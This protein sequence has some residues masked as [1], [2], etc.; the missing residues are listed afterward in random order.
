LALRS[1]RRRRLAAGFH[2]RN[3]VLV[4]GSRAVAWMKQYFEGNIPRTEYR[5]IGYFSVPGSGGAEVLTGRDTATGGPYAEWS[6]LG[7]VGDLGQILIST[8]IH[9][10]IVIQP[11]GGSDWLK[12]VVDD[13]DYFGITVR[14]VP[15]PLLYENLRDLR[16]AYRGDPFNLPEIVLKP[17]GLESDALFVKRVFDIV[18]GLLLLLLTAPLLLLIA[19]AIKLTTPSLPVLYRWRVVG[20]KG[21]PF[22]SYKF[23]TMVA[24]ADQRK[25]ALRSRNE[26]NGPVFKMKDDPRA[27]PLGQFLR[28]YSLNELP[29]I[30]SVVRG[31]MSLVGPRPAFPHEL[32]RYELWH[33]RKLSVRPG[34]T[35][36]WQTRGRNRINNFDDWVRMDLEYIDNWSLWLDLKILIRTAWVVVAGTGS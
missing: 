28:R 2:A 26:M 9:E 5:A 24:D 33:K 16:F 11:S 22:T 20:Y 4:G 15:E 25:D 32:E 1:Y 10:V 35:C 3:V 34:I 27:T 7:A 30:W 23:T 13:C 14:I 12:K 6:C 36:L 19:L 8:P 21:K 17:R 29:Q 31:D 18:V